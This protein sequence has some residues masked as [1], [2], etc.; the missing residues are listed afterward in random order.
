MHTY[1]GRPPYHGRKF[2]CSLCHEASESRLLN[3]CPLTCADVSISQCVQP[4]SPMA[5]AAK[6]SLRFIPVPTNHSRT[7]TILP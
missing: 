6:P 3:D 1:R 7:F 2:C 5:V 4:Q